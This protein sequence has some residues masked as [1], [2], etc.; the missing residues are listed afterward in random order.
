MK[1]DHRTL[2]A[3]ADVDRD[4]SPVGVPVLLLAA[5]AAVLAT[6][7]AIWAVTETSAAWAMV[8][9]IVVALC[10]T[11]G[12]IAVVERQL[13]DSDPYGRGDEAG[14]DP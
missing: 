3:A 7:A 1:P 13:A 6:V 11:V 8:C 4:H 14:T 12:L 10:G 9:A 5:L 2:R